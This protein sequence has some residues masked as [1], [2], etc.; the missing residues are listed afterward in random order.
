MRV[1]QRKRDIEE[2][3]QAKWVLWGMM[4]DLLADLAL[5][6]KMCDN[7]IRVAGMQLLN[8]TPRTLRRVQMVEEEVEVEVEVEEHQQTLI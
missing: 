1:E 8:Q 5:W 4:R 6:M 3:K 2:K 7:L